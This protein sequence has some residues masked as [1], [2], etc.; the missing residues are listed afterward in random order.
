LGI[1]IRH[2][3]GGQAFGYGGGNIEVL[4]PRGD[5][6]PPEEVHDEES[7]VM[8]VTFGN[9]SV[10]LTGDQ[11]RRVETDLAERGQL[12]ATDVLK[13]G[14]HGSKTSTGEVF[15]DQVRPL[16][17]VI[18]V[19]LDNPYGHPHPAVLAALEAHRSTVLRTDTWG[20]ISIL[21]D[22]GRRIQVDMARWSREPRRL[23]SAF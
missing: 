14:H 17:A 15:Q 6:A 7:L 18:S 8:R 4:A 10:L 5:V 9:R 3:S 12:R 1:R 21:T 20:L 11:G 16:F 19:G 13:V 22:G 2:L 23:F